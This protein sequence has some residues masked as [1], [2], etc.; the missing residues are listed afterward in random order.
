MNIRTQDVPSVTCRHVL[1]LY[2]RRWVSVNTVVRGQLGSCYLEHYILGLWTDHLQSVPSKVP[3]SPRNDS[4]KVY[5]CKNNSKYDCSSCTP[6][7]ST[8]E[9]QRHDRI[10]KAR[11]N[12]E[13]VV[14]TRVTK[15]H[16]SCIHT[17]RSRCTQIQ[18]HGECVD[19]LQH[20]E[21]FPPRI[22]RPIVA[23]LFQILLDTDES[24]Q[25]SHFTRVLYICRQMR[26]LRRVLNIDTCS[27][28]HRYGACVPKALY[29]FGFV[30]GGCV[31]DTAVVFQ[32]YDDSNVNYSQS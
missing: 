18:V 14:Q 15:K 31:D 13:T 22:T 11:S 7:H 20:D 2:L 32:R 28:H 26:N 1:H 24:H 10:R 27:G 23:R 5:C 16:H 6:V 3:A 19:S 4:Y 8:G 9:Q 21:S 25:L 17:A 29:C 12:A 30:S